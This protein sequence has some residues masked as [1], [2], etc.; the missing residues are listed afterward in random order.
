MTARTR[1]QLAG[2]ALVLGL[3]LSGCAPQSSDLDA[4]VGHSMQTI[5]VIAANQAASG[6]TSAA[7]LTLDT[8]Q[9]QLKQAIDMHQIS[10]ER[11]AKVQESLD[12][13][14]ADLQPVVAPAPPNE[15]AAPSQ[16][17]TESPSKGGNGNDE[18][19]KGNEKGKEKGKGK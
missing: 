2:A 16:T 19:G 15:P 4:S 17:T 7:L 8:L 11:A 18:K 9:T 6:N 14:R 5:V 10:T 1:A 3:V 12:L 13:V